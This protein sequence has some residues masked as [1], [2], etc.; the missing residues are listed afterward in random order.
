MKASKLT[1]NKNILWESSRMML[2]EHKAYLVERRETLGDRVKPSLDSQRQ[3]QLSEALAYALAHKA[4]VSLTLFTPKENKH[5]HGVLLKLD[6][7][8][9]RLKVSCTDRIC[10]INLEDIIEIEHE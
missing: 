10:W 1:P 7:Q 4:E 6:E 3:D 9:R 8:L 5:I 2:P